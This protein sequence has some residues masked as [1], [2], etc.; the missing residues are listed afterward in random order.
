MRKVN[1]NIE[2]ESENSLFNRIEGVFFSLR[3]NGLKTTIDKI[4]Q[5]LLYKVKGVDFSSQNIA[6]LTKTGA[7]QE[8]GTA[9]ISSSKD[10]LAT[11]FW[12]LEKIIGK[13]LSK[14]LFIDY[15]SGKGSAIIHARNLGFKKSIGVEFAKELHEIAVENIQK[16]KIDNVES[17]YI[18]AGVYIPPKEVSIFYFYNPFTEV[19]MKEV[20]KNIL[21][22]KE[23]FEEDV[24]II[25]RSG[26]T[27]LLKEHFEFIKE[28]VYPSGARADFYKITKA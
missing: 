8:E 9:L 18:D 5:H 22:E 11:L 23:N 26:S 1:T 4:G 24:Y 20:I 3:K 25:Y 6:T 2:V 27:D 21:N 16:F 7:N 10:F 28:I 12:D 15:G 17:L 19:V 14:Q 13:P